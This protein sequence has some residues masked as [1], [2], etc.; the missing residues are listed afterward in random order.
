MNKSEK[1]NCAQKGNCMPCRTATNKLFHE[2]IYNAM[3]KELRD[4]AGN[5][6][7]AFEGNLPQGEHNISIDLSQYP[8]GVYLIREETSGLM[9]K[10]AKR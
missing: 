9:Q 4:L 5:E 7:S 3:L 8:S 2:T 6:K 1:N 10:V